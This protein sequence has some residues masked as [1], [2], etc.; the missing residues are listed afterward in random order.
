MERSNYEGAMQSFER[1]Q[2]QMRHDKRRSLL[3]VSLVSFPMGV[4]QRIENS[5]TLTDIG[6]EI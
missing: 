5:P 3:V 2:A 1:A 6:M 4:L